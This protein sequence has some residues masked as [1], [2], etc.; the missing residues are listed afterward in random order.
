MIKHGII[1]Q[2]G[3]EFM[4]KMKGLC[5]ILAL[6]FIVSGVNSSVCQASSWKDY[7]VDTYT[8]N[9]TSSSFISNGDMLTD[10]MVKNTYRNNWGTLE[11]E[12]LVN[13]TWTTAFQKTTCPSFRMLK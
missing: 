12:K 6:V 3:G 2:K 11:I 1:M 4:K 5:L 10:F 13:G 9:Y 8:S 7:N